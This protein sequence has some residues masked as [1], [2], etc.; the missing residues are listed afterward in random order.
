MELEG[1]YKGYHG[2]SVADDNSGT[3]KYVRI[4]YS[5]IPLN[6]N[7]EIN[8]LTLGS[9]GSG[10]TIEYVQASYGLD[11]SFEWFGGTVNAKYLIAYK[12]TDDDFDVD[13]GYSGNVQLNVLS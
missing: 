11:D 5:G 6:P 4:E 8:S 1:G 2:G 13:N 3:L 7:Q 10:T 12:G 9:V